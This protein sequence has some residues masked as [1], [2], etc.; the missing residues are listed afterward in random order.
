MRDEPIKI[1]LTVE[2][3]G[4]PAKHTVWDYRTAFLSYLSSYLNSG[5]NHVDS[6]VERPSRFFSQVQ[7][8]EEKI[9]NKEIYFLQYI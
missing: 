8:P 1:T 7:A 6:W 3:V 2:V 5:R 9:R 4:S